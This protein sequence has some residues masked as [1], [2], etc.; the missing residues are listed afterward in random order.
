MP[1][2]PPLNQAPTLAI[3]ITKLYR[4]MQLAT[5]ALLQ[6]RIAWAQ[7]RVGEFSFSLHLGRGRRTYLRHSQIPTRTGLLKRSTMQHEFKLVYGRR[8]IAEMFDPE[9]YH[10]WKS[11]AELKNNLGPHHSEPLTPLRHLSHIVLHEFSHF[12]QSVLGQRYNGSVHNR[13][14]YHI[15]ERSYAAD[16]DLQVMQFL[17]DACGDCPETIAALHTG[18]GSQRL[19]LPTA[20]AFSPRA[21]APH[22]FQRGQQVSFVYR[23]KTYTGTITRLNKQRASVDCDSAK[24]PRALIP[25]A[26]LSCLISE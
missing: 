21:R 4:G 15:L 9:Q 13:E 3:D 17:L 20:A 24:F 7:E 16:S 11:F 1:S 8:C 22:G 14:F 6:P 19:P 10:R 12:V 25:Y 26:Q 23:R 18:Y 2:T 5:E